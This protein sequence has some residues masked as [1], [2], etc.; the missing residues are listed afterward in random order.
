MEAIVKERET[1]IS[2]H[3]KTIDSLKNEV[4]IG[5]K[6][7]NEYETK[8]EVAQSYM[9]NCKREQD[10]MRV[11]YETANQL[12]VD[13][14]KQDW[15]KQIMDLKRENEFLRE[16]VAQKSKEFSN[17]KNNLAMAIQTS[18]NPNSQSHLTNLLENQSRE[19]VRLTRMI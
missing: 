8:F 13:L 10:E 14:K 18:G 12:L 4:T 19:L 17:L 3:Q 16:E 1:V 2:G 11:R 9:E 15:T 7:C 5:Q 6:R